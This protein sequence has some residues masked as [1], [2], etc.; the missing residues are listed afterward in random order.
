MHLL[1]TG[2]NQASKKTGILEEHQSGWIN[3]LRAKNP[4]KLGVGAPLEHGSIDAILKLRER[5]DWADDFPCSSSVDTFD[6]NP[7]WSEKDIHIRIYLEAKKVFRVAPNGKD[8]FYIG[9]TGEN[10]TMQGTR[11]EDRARI[12]FRVHVGY[13]PAN[14]TLPNK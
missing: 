3:P 6:I 14:L 9:R 7:S 5:D 11:G 10:I 12:T 2:G 1:F 4:W 13:T 8:L